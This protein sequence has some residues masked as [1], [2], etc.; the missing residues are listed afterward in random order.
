MRACLVLLSLTLVACPGPEPNGD[1][2]TPPA[3][4]PAFSTAAT[5]W[6]L[7]TW[8]PSPDDVYM[9][10]GTTTKAAVMHFDGTAWAPLTLGV[11]APLLNWTYGF[12]PDDITMVGNAGTV[13][14][15]DGQ[16]WTKET[17]PTTQDLWGVWGAAPD[18][19]WAVGGDGQK[20]G[21]ATLLHFDGA[22]WSAVTLPAMQK[23][24]VFQLLKVWGTG[25]DNVYAV[26]QRG[27]VLH[28]TGTDWK[29]ELVGASDD[30]ISLWGTGPDRIVA[31][32]GR[33]N[34]IASVWD[35]TSWHTTSLSPL[36][37]LNG[38]WMRVPGKAHVVGAYG[39]LGVL[40]LATM[41]IT[42]VDPPT[43]LDFHSVFGDTQGHLYAV[44]GN[45]A[46]ANPTTYVGLAYTRLLGAEE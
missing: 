9:V 44:G 33:S 3:W 18:D 25:P 5:G 21:Q 32:G 46:S 14:H 16:T 41:T 26:G 45:L 22:A 30:L 27:E 8:G 37:G 24:N 31:V 1:A 29:E 36:P 40:D 35:G 17:T 38:V 34:G 39:T 42:T 20:A 23:P 7:N 4:A 28:W 15:W 6:L 12:G 13:L 2:G 43:Q 11:D 10:G 19:L